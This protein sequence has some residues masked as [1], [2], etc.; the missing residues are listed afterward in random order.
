M[1]SFLMVSE[2]PSQDA[3]R[4]LEVSSEVTRR[5]MPALGRPLRGDF[6]D[7]PE[8]RGGWFTLAIDDDP[9]PAL[10]N[11]Y[12]DDA[13]A[14][15]IYGEMPDEPH[16]ICRAVL[17]N[18]PTATYELAGEFAA[19]VV[20]R[21]HRT[22]TLTSTLLNRF[23]IRH[24]TDDAGPFGVASF[25]VSLVAAGLAPVNPD[26]ATLASMLKLEYGLNGY[27]F[28]QGVRD[29]RGHQ[30]IRRTSGGSV[31]QPAGWRLDSQSRIAPKDCE[32]VKRQGKVVQQLMLSEVA[33]RVRGMSKIETD[34]TAG[35]D[36]R[37]V[38]AALLATLGPKRIECS[39]A[40]EPDSPDVDVARRLAR[41]NGVPF[42]V[43]HHEE[44]TDRFVE[45]L[46]LLAFY[47]NG[48]TNGKRATVERTYPAAGVL[49]GHGGGGGIY[50]DV[51]SVM[52]L[53]PPSGGARR[54]LRDFLLNR[55]PADLLPDLLQQFAGRLDE[56]LDD[57]QSISSDPWDLAT[58]LYAFGR[59]SQWQAHTAVVP[60]WRNRYSPLVSS[61]LFA[62]AMRLPPPLSRT[63]D[64]HRALIV[65]HVRGGGWIPVNHR[66]RL[67][68][69][70]EELWK[71]GLRWLDSRS[72]LRWQ[73][74][75]SRRKESKS[76]RQS[77]DHVRSQ[78]FVGRYADPIVEIL[79]SEDSCM[80]ALFGAERTC[81]LL[82]EH[83]SGRIDYTELFGRILV[84]N[85]YHYMLQEARR[86]ARSMTI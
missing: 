82:E 31:S 3:R 62:A 58:N 76:R 19:V 17:D 7:L 53:S 66:Q 60:W 6:V 42:S 28:L 64:L 49:H 85:R 59:M 29:L 74:W 32:G 27:G 4:R 14:G 10:I 5:L 33:S 63:L 84:M 54:N 24:T 41:L 79:K 30:S 57:L 47:M 70:G 12:I 11:T 83:R 38:F 48:L 18:G 61:S 26:R 34:L 72:A 15:L 21:H 45:N 86:L 55:Q 78:M 77:V 36:T 44:P 69:A 75:R 22:V 8:I 25:E 40:G 81:E 20:D 68:L 52:A 71:T 39:A 1:Y 50:K 65:H 35:L 51:Y 67:V 9:W 56:T 16:R 23:G 46:D 80:P 37:A 2:C 43:D 73:R 13:V